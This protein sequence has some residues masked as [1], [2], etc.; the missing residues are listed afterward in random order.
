MS[1]E[2]SD[3]HRLRGTG[4][5]LT[6]DD[7]FA[8]TRFFDAARLLEEALARHLTEHHGMNISDYEVL[9]RLDGAGDEMRLR[10]LAEQCVSSKSKLTHTLVRLEDRGWI[11]REKAP[12]DGRGVVA[13]LLPAGADAL[14]AASPRHAAIIQDRLLDCWDP[15]D[16]PVIAAAMAAAATRMRELRR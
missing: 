11:R 10:D 5:H 12:G 7:L 16:R 14:A 13:A 6:P 8:F 4:A 3:A 1:E 15:A 9:V 2:A